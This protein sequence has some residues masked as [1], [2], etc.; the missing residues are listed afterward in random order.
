VSTPGN[1]LRLQ[2]PTGPATRSGKGCYRYWEDEQ[3]LE[4]RVMPGESIYKWAAWYQTAPH[5]I[6]EWNGLSK[7]E[8][9]VAGRRMLVRLSGLK[10]TQIEVKKGDTLYSIS[11]QFD[12]E[13]TYPLTSWNCLATTEKLQVGRSMVILQK[14]SIPTQ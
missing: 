4:K 1:T 6:A 13:S 5:T 7:E 12:L 9:I 3:I 14:E 10:W 8:H 11:K 2:R